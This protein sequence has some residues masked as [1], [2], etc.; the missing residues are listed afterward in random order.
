MKAW[1]TAEVIAVGT[2]LLVGATVNGNAAWLGRVLG[3]AGLELRHSSMVDDDL[4]RMLA[5]LRQ[6]TARADLVVLTGGL[7]PTPDDLTREAI[8]A[9]AGLP[10]VEDSEALAHV[11]RVFAERGRPMSPS[12]LRQARLPQGAELIPN[13]AGTA[14]GVAL[15]TPGDGAIW[16]FPGVPWELEA[17]WGPWAPERLAARV[18]GVVLSRWLRFSGIGESLLAEQQAALLAG[19]NPSVAPYAGAGE[20]ALRVRAQAPSPEE[21]EALLGPVVARLSSVHPWCYGTGEAS[22]ATTVVAQLRAQGATLGLGESCTGGLIAAT[23]TDAPGATQALAGGTVAYTPQA[24]VAL[25]GLTEG[26]LAAGIVSEA[27]ASEM[28]RGAQALHGST[29]GLGITGWAGPSE[30]PGAEPGLVWLAVSGPDGLSVEARRFGATSPRGVVKRLAT[31]AALHH[32]RLR[33]AGLGLDGQAWGG[34]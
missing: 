33:L 32:L 27:V 19:T 26:A 5:A 28:A 29:W 6:A 20:V 18:Q 22:L 8:A 2:E 4:E 12:N 34:R 31:A 25:L 15:S 11:H 13:P 10:L 17:M 7:G 30:E 16:A 3:D 14:V 21:A 9:W 23:L 24:K 1:A